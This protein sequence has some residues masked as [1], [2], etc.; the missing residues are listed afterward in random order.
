M[1]HRSTQP[2]TSLISKSS[3]PATGRSRIPGA[4][5]DLAKTLECGQVFHWTRC[6]A[7]FVGAIGQTPS[8]LAQ[9]GQDR[10]VPEGQETRVHHYVAVAHCINV[11]EARFPNA[12]TIRAAL[13]L[14]RGS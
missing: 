3:I 10:I 14:S 13:R 1:A 8:Y 7:G 2:V 6:E 9:V 12:P 4:G 5:I 11:I